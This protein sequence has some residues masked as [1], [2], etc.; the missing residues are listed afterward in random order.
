[1]RKEQRELLN[2][3]LAVGQIMSNVIFNFSQK[4]GPLWDFKDLQVQW[5]KYH[6]ELLEAL[7]RERKGA[8]R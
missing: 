6:R 4:N 8:A 2:H 5:D 7:R 3:L 1:M